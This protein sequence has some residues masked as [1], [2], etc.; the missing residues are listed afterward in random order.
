MEMDSGSDQEDESKGRR[1]VRDWR[2]TLHVLQCIGYVTICLS[3]ICRH[4]W[5]IVGA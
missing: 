3:Y 5:T 2:L 4:S 1:A